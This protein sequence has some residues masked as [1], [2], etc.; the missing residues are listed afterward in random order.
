MSWG[1]ICNP[2]DELA[3]DRRPWVPNSGWP[4]IQTSLSAYL[5]DALDFCQV[6]REHRHRVAAINRELTHE[7]GLAKERAVVTPVYFGLRSAGV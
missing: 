7:A 1:G 4:P 5:E 6:A 3:F 2:L